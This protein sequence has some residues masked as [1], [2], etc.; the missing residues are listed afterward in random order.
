MCFR[1]LKIL[2]LADYLSF[3]SRVCRTR[4]LWK[5]LSLSC[6]FHAFVVVFT[7]VAGVADFPVA[8][9]G[10]RKSC[11]KSHDDDGTCL[12]SNCRNTWM[13][14]VLPAVEKRAKYGWRYIQAIRTYVFGRP[15]CIFGQAAALRT[16]D[17]ENDVKRAFAWVMRIPN[18]W[19]LPQLCF[20]FFFVIIAG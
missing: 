17:N 19:W 18:T 5:T 11:A 8:C 14:G 16:V 2:E 3:V 7:A 20:F 13:P 1:I 15:V 9:V 10:G 4:L 12:W 6:L